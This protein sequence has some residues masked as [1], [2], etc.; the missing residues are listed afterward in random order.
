MP[1]ASAG[2]AQN[3]A[4]STPVCE[5]GGELAADVLDVQLRKVEC[6]V[7]YVFIS[8][9]ICIRRITLYIAP[10]IDVSSSLE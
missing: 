8:F 5:E 1:H 4:V 7:D 10:A 9:R 6:R 3:A 2:F